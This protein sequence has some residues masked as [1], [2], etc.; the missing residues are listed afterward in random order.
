MIEK[1]RRDRG[2]A[3]FGKPVGDAADVRI[4]AEDFLHHDDATLRSAR[5]CSEIRADALHA[6][7]IEIDVLTHGTPSVSIPWLSLRRGLRK[8][9]RGARRPARIAA[10]RSTPYSGRVAR[11]L[12]A[13]VGLGHIDG[14]VGG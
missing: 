6:A 1:C 5:R 7:R 10:T 2:V 8:S 9:M 14:F 11:H 4:D 12:V 13:A 3:M